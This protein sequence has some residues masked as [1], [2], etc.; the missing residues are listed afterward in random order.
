MRG[1]KKKN[2]VW[3]TNHNREKPRI[4]KAVLPML[5]FNFIFGNLAAS[6]K[7]EDLSARR[8][9]MSRT[10]NIMEIKFN[11]INVFQDALQI[12]FITSITDQ[13]GH[14]RKPRL[15]Y[16]NSVEVLDSTD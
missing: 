12:N 2:V 10:K 14:K 9:L 8:N 15:I 13:Y 3:L 1:L 4:G 16:A 11:H 5:L 7:T 6:G